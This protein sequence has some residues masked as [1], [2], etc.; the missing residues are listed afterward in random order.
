MVDG[1][2][3]LGEVDVLNGVGIG[4]CHSI[5]DFCHVVV[6]GRVGCGFAR[7]VR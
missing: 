6:Q 1:E 2:S 3:D 4:C 7:G 5:G